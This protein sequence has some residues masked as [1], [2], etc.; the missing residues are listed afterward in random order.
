[1]QVRF[2]LKFAS[3]VLAFMVGLP[4][5]AADQGPRAR[6]AIHVE[7]GDWGNARAEDVEKVLTAVA[8][9]L[10]PYVPQRAPDRIAVEPSE[11][12][13]RV[14]FEKSPDGA[15]RV[16]LSVKDTRWDQFAYQFSHELC[17][18]F[19]NFEQ[20]EI[21]RAGPA[22]DHQWFEESLCEAVALFALDRLPATWERSPPY[23]GWE[24]YAPAFRAYA[25]RVLSAEHRH[26]SPNE[27]IAAWYRTNRDELARNP[28]LRQENERLAARLL[29]L[30]EGMPGSLKAIAYL[31]L[32][33]S[34]SQESFRAYLESWYR[35]CPGESRA[36]I[37]Q[38]MS[39]LGERNASAVVAEAP[40][41]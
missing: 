35:C 13:P 34:S 26:P 23:P 8:G 32:E 12:G 36:F 19:T 17:H 37:V 29:S 18:I 3:F 16:Q 30:L 31:N 28:Y 40:A 5:P 1:M 2:P 22:R 41:L 10:L 21:G 27:S 7:R 25:Q 33:D 24:G 4:A 20:R 15:Y 39:L 6:M 38:V 9:V 11:S 14:L